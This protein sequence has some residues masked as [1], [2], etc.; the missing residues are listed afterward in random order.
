MRYQRFP[1]VK[2][3]LL[4]VLLLWLPGSLSAQDERLRLIIH[5][6][7]QRDGAEVNLMASVLQPGRAALDLSPEAFAVTEAGRPVADLAVQPAEGGM[8]VAL[9]IDRGGI[10]AQWGCSGPTGQLRI[11]EAKELA[12]SI[13]D[14]LVIGTPE[15]PDDMVALLGIGPRDAEGVT[16]FRPRQDFT[17]NP[18]DRNLIL[19]SLEPIDAPGDYLLTASDVTPLYDGMNLSLD[20][21]TRNSDPI[22]R[23]QLERR[24][25]VMIVFSDGIDNLYSDRA[26]ELSLINRANR[27]NVSIYAINLG[28]AGPQR[29]MDPQGLTQ[30]SA[31]THG[32][33]W[34]HTTAAERAQIEA[35]IP[36][37]L[38]YRN[39]YHLSFITRLLE[40]EYT[41]RVSVETELGSDFDEVR[42]FSPLRRPEI[43]FS[44]PSA[45][46]RINYAQAQDTALPVEVG[47]NFPDAISRDLRVEFFVGDVPVHT[48]EAPPYR[49]EWDLGL[50]EAGRH[51]ITARA[52]DPLLAQEG[53]LEISREIEIIAPTPTPDPTPIP[54]TPTP[55]PVVPPPPE[56]AGNIFQWLIIPL[57]LVIL[58]LVY[59]LVRTRKQVATV[60]ATGVRRAT[61]RLTRVLSAAPRPARARLVVTRG[62][63]PQRE[64]L[65]R[66]NVT[67]FGREQDL[68]DEVINDSYA[69]ATHFSITYDTDQSAFFV[70]DHDSRN[71]TFLNGQLL[72]PNQY[73]PIQWGNTIRI[74]ETELVFQRVGG[75]T[76]VLNSNP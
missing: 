59:L 15:R 43:S 28:C 26:E 37:L 1:F 11:T 49:Y 42:F 73:V 3:L 69:S 13:I 68:C 72:P 24:Q 34:P 2:L 53:V 44:Q 55:T 23:E 47:A 33:Y 54:P 66:D 41:I 32:Q 6:Q 14:Q 17:F 31:Q 67:R 50:L 8:A 38:T 76:R 74:G 61:T 7:P 25:K 75:T 71:G 21:L 57:I 51:V 56:V 36:S 63:N 46:Y 40:G 58:I 18:V 20:W 27:D 39:Q 52:L 62:V 65:I 12:A 4:F 9:V 45:G 16:E 19:N 48:A 35:N 22:V 10:A 5:G 30:M 64:Y 70:M 60:M 29:R